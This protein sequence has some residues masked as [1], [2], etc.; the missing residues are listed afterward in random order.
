[1]LQGVHGCNRD[2]VREEG[3][4]GSI[5]I[6]VVIDLLGGLRV[7]DTI[8]GR[9]CPDGG[10]QFVGRRDTFGDR[11]GH[12]HLGLLAHEFVAPIAITTTNIATVRNIFFI[13]APFF[14]ELKNY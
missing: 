6:E 2:A 8:D 4:G 1:M 5:K 14:M 13:V 10:F 9:Q 11:C 3:L 12:F 7:W